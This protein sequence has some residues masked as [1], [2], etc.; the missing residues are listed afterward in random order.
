MIGSTSA[1]IVERIVNKALE[2]SGARE[3]DL[4]TI[5]KNSDTTQGG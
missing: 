2:L 5:E 1:A 3:S 4:K